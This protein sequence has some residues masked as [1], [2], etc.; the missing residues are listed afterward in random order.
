MAHQIVTGQVDQPA[1]GADW[2]FTPSASDHVR[3]LTV[4]AELTTA[5]AVA[6]RIPALAFKDQGG[7]VYWSAD[8]VTP[9]AASLTVRYSWSRNMSLA[10]ASAVVTGERVSAG[11]PDEWLLPGDTVESI[12]GALAAA[13]QWSSIVWR[14]IVG[15][16]WEDDRMVAAIARAFRGAGG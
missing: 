9:Q 4:T 16:S 2:R 6:N 8:T 10:V 15:D 12:T 13:D 7:L 14:G 11:M 1:A 3:L 5:I